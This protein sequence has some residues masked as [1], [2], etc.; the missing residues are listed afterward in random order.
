MDQVAPIE[1]LEHA[2]IDNY[3]INYAAKK[4]YLSKEDMLRLFSDHEGDFIP[5]TVLRGGWIYTTEED[6]NYGSPRHKP[7]G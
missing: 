7:W 2:G 6:L 3:N 1:S 5:V 4:I